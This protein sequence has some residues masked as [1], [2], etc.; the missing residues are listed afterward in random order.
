MLSWSPRCPVVKCVRHRGDVLVMMFCSS[1]VFGTLVGRCLC[2]VVRVADDICILVVL[3]GH[4]CTSAREW[5][6][7][8]HLR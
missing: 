4:Q 1:V 8:S 7:R 6:V 5:N 2:Y 3:C